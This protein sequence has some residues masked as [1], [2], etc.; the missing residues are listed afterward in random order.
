MKAR[1]RSQKAGVVGS[2]EAARKGFW[3]LTATKYDDLRSAHDLHVYRL[4]LWADYHRRFKLFLPLHQLWLDYMSEL[5]GL[6]NEAPG[7]VGHVDDGSMPSAAGMHA[8]LVKADFHGA[9]ITGTSAYQ[10]PYHTLVDT[11][12]SRFSAA[13]QEPVPG[14]SLR[15]RNP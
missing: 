3:K 14:W 2:R 13:E 5:L 1:K 4:C 6:S 9:I 11:V 15:H 10:S 12:W 7:S 8:K